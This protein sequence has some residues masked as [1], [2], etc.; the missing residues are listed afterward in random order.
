M[1]AVPPSTFY[2]LANGLRAFARFVYWIAY[3]VAVALCV[4]CLEFAL[5]ASGKVVVVYTFLQGV[6]S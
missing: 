3:C 6:T 5:V 4:S 1:R 2:I